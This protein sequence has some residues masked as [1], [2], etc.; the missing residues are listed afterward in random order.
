MRIL[1][2]GKNGQL[3]RHLVEKL[4]CLAVICAVDIQEL[5]ISDQ[6]AVNNRVQ[7]DQPD[8]IINA[9]AYTAVEQADNEVE[10]AFKVNNDGVKFLAQAAKNIGAVIIHI[11][12][13]YVFDGS[14]I[15]PYSEMDAA[16]P[17]N[18]YGKSKLAGE[19]EVIQ[20]CP[21]HIIIRTAWLFSEQSNNFVS[22]MLKLGQK[23]NE[24]SI[25]DD[26]WGGPTYAGD[27]ADAIVHIVEQFKQAG[28]V[29]WGV[30]HFSGWPHVTWYQFA[31]IIFNYAYEQKMIN[32]VPKLLSISSKAYPSNVN[33]PVNSRLNCT[34]I[35]E[36]FGIDMGDWAKALPHVI[37]QLIDKDPM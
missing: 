29:D 36:R 11:S 19:G 37:E 23:H 28:T 17:Q 8:I 20:I 32:K 9:A 21:E 3:G 6:L 33:R 18:V 30:Y 7:Q 12:T 24:L 1:I 4:N 14:K 5:D 27:L 13:D 25:V 22:T 16:L 31:Q 35:K 15:L 2:V 34:K 10:Q 26:Q